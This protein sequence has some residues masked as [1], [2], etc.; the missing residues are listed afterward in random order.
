MTRDAFTFPDLDR[1]ASLWT[2]SAACVGAD[3][4]WFFSHDPVETAAAQS[5]C[6]SCPVRAECL[7]HAEAVPEQHGVWGGV[8]LDVRGRA[9]LHSTKRPRRTRKGTTSF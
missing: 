1:R 6:G 2:E 3:P 8:D 7:T 4:E 5:L 9:A